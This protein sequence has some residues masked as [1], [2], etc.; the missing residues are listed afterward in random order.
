MDAARGR[1]REQDLPG[2]GG[3]QPPGDLRVAHA[4]RSGGEGPHGVLRHLAA[5]GLA[6]PR[7]P[8]RRRPGERPARGALCLLPGGAARDEAAHRLDRALPRLLDGA[9]RSPRTT[10]GENGR[11]TPVENTAPSQCESLSFELALPHAPEKVWR[12]LTDPALLAEWLL[13]VV[14]LKLEPGA[15]FTLKSQPQPGWDGT[16]SCRLLEIE[17]QRRLS[18]KWV[19]G[20]I[21]TIVTFTLTPTDSG[22]RLT[23]LQSGFKPD[24]KQN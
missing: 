3:P 17:E 9:H 10:A 15:A 21:D 23:V 1:G 20:D 12:A 19:V 14:G 2:A 18:W 11:M 24:Q 13:P 4:W 8:E 6:A 22:T 7:H 16:V 5:G